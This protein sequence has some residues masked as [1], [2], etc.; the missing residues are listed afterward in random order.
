MATEKDASAFQ[1]NIDDDEFDF[2]DDALAINLDL[3]EVDAA[4]I[5]AE[6]ETIVSDVSV[7]SMFTIRLES[8]ALDISNPE[9]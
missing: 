8:A 6:M 4:E 1:A 5:D 2:G 7:L 3:L 9:G